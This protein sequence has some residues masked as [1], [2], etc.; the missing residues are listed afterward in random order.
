MAHDV[1]R[2]LQLIKGLG[3]RHKLLLSHVAESTDLQV[4]FTEVNQLH[5]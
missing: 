3:V 1:Q 4:M 2:Q 5:C